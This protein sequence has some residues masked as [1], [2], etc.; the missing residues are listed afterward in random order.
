MGIPLV[1]GA[2]QAGAALAKG[3][4]GARQS[5]KANKALKNFQRQELRNITEGMRISTLKAEQETKE[6][7]RRFSTSVEALRSAGVRGLMGGLPQQ[8]Q[9]EQAQQQMISADLDR[10][11][12]QIEMMR[13]EDEARIQGMQE[14]RDQF[15]IGRLMGEQA[16]G[17]QQ[18]TSAIGDF[19]S[20][21][22]AFIPQAGYG[23]VKDLTTLE[24]QFGAIKENRGLLGEGTFETKRTGFLGLGG[25]KDVLTGYKG[26]KDF[27][28]Q[29]LLSNVS[30]FTIPRP[31]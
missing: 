8:V 16:A 3:I 26:A 24:D 14:R 19:A 5:S 13:A 25:K 23:R 17:R 22:T 6:S 27:A 31:N 20:A 2:I 30:S 21:A 1:I 11:Q 29:A 10:Q 7:Q 15:E 28:N 18:I 12:R 4:A 9:L